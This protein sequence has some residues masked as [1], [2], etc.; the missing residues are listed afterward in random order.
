MRPATITTTVL[1]SLFAMTAHA[2]CWQ[3]AG[4]RYRVDP[5]LLYSIAKKESRLRPGAIG[6]NKDGTEDLGLMQINS[7]HLPALRQYGITRAT[8]LGDT[9][10][11][12][13]V[14]AW[15]LSSNL[16][17]HGNNTFALG[18][19][20]AGTRR[21]PTQEQ[22]RQAYAADVLRIYHQEMAQFRP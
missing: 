8:L 10:S 16:Y 22:R 20:N 13:M 3:A 5:W 2:N 6:V 18:A 11:N 21:T 7:R 9:C 17:R 14:G 1:I 19:Y 15:I 12:I 4:E